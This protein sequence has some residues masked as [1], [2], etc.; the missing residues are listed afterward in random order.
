MGYTCQEGVSKRTKVSPK[1]KEQCRAALFQARWPQGFEC[2]ECGRKR[3]CRCGRNVFQDCRHQVDGRHRLRE[4]QAAAEEM[5]SR[6]A[7]P[8]EER[9]LGDG[10]G[11]SVGSQ[12]QH[13]LVAEA[14]LMQVMKERDE[15]GR[16]R[17]GGRCLPGGRNPRRPRGA[18]GKTPLVAAVQVTEEGRPVAL[19]MSCVKGFRKQ[20]IATPGPTGICGGRR[21]SKRWPA[22]GE[23]RKQVVSTARG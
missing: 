7:D 23:W 14:K 11:A 9:S 15:S 1:G 22:S 17:A 10:P 6:Q 20:E 16:L 3:C 21:W 2:P 4:H 5:V 13:G 8:V 12:L 19:R 18:Q